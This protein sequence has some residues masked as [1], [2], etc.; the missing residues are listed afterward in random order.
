MV[1]LAIAVAVGPRGDLRHRIAALALALWWAL[2]RRA[3][4]TI[5]A[6]CERG[7]WQRALAWI[8]RAIHWQLITRG[9]LLDARALA[10]QALGDV[11][12]AVAREYQQQGGESLLAWGD[13]L[14]R[15]GRHT[16]ARAAWALV[17]AR[18]PESES[19]RIAQART[20]HECA[21]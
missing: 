15:Q 13:L 1:L 7:E 18:D 16:E 20:A 5:D 9:E 11:D 10:L 8:D 17:V 4:A 2:R 19:A 3:E 12:G 14:L 21:H 6:C